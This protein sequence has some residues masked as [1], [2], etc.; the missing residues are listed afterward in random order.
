MEDVRIPP[1]FEFPDGIAANP[2]VENLHVVVR[3]HAG[4]GIMDQAHVAVAEVLV[5]IPARIYA[6]ATAVG[7]RVADEKEMRLGIEEHETTLS[8]TL[9]WCCLLCIPPGSSLISA[10]IIHQVY[11]NL[12]NARRIML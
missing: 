4:Q 1:G 6:I 3:V 9:L 2:H 5:G 7:N 12:L 10:M 8:E 11:A